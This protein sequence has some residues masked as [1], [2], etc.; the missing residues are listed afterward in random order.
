MKITTKGLPWKSSDATT[1]PSMFGKRNAGAFVPRGSMVL[2]VLTI[3]EL[4]ST[5]EDCSPATERARNRW[6]H[7]TDCSKMRQRAFEY[8]ERLASQGT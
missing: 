8:V 6:S 2:A 3:V 5:K 7:C 4:P 1:L